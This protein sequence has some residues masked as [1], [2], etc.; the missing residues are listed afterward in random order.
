MYPG[1]NCW[2]IDTGGLDVA[3]PTLRKAIDQ[4]MKAEKQGAN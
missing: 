1:A 4:A 3:G 2:W